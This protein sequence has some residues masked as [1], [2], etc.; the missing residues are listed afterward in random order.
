MILKTAFAKNI[1]AIEDYVE[2]FC[3]YQRVRPLMNIYLGAYDKNCELK[4][5]LDSILKLGDMFR[6]LPSRIPFV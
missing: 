4:Y 3:K 2:L 5:G 1:G 6:E